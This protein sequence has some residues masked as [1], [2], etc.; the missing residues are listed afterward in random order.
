MNRAE[1]LTGLNRL[2]GSDGTFQEL[3]YNART[4]G[5][6]AKHPSGSVSPSGSGGEYEM[7]NGEGE[8][9]RLDCWRCGRESE[10]PAGAPEEPITLRCPHCGAALQGCWRPATEGTP[11][12]D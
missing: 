5:V 10:H 1:R 2:T 12:G 7:A 8:L 9:Y 6:S 3:F 4:W 11:D